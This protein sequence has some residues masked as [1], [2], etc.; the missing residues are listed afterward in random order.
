MKLLLLILATSF[1]FL[2]API[3]WASAPRDIPLGVTTTPAD[4]SWR[5]VER[6]KVKQKQAQRQHDTVLIG[7][8]ITHLWDDRAADLLKAYFGDVL[9][10]GFSG[11][12]TQDT[13]ASIAQMDW[14]RI[15]PKRIMIMIGTN[16]TGWAKDSPEATFD[17][18]ELIIRNLRAACP[19]AKI[20][21]L[22]V[23]PR[24]KPNQAYATVANDRL[25]RLLPQLADEE[26]VYF[27]NINAY[28]L[29]ADG[30]TLAAE[31]FSDR[32]HP[33]RLGYRVWAAAIAREF[34]RDYQ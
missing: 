22:A 20:T 32:L 9:N 24:D 14:E 3:G 30:K 18:I 7:D 23:F 6:R 31:L 27:R 34:M 16:N 21:L 10:L 1:L 17:G 28:F 2:A 5:W 11:D 4:Q 15:D 33:N 12:R 26:H 19:R 25:N 13:L 8:S 29:Q